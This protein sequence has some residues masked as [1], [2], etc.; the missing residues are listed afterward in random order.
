[1][2]TTIATTA[3]LRTEIVDVLKL[4]TDDYVL[5][6]E[7]LDED[8]GV[9]LVVPDDYEQP[10]LARVV[11]WEADKDGANAVLLDDPTTIIAEI[12]PAA[13]EQIRRVLPDQEHETW[14]DF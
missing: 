14:T 2:P 6:P 5:L 10:L 12:V 3:A 4:Q 11:G 7:D 13:G 8:G 9:P 1:M